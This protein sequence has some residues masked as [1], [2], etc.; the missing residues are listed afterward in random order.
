VRLKVTFEVELDERSDL[1]EGTVACLQ[2][3]LAVI[4]RERRLTVPVPGGSR[5]PLETEIPF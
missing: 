4:A 2:A 5:D 3:C 1:D